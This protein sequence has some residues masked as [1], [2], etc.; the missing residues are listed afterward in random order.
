MTESVEA[1][2]VLIVEDE[3]ATRALLGDTFIRPGS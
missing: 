2:L 1:P 3:P